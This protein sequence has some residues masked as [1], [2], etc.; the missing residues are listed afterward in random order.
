MHINHCKHH[1][2]SFVNTHCD[3]GVCYRDVTT[4]PDRQDG[5]AWRKPCIVARES[6]F[7]N[8]GQREE[9]AKRGTCDKFELPTAEEVAADEVRWEAKLKETLKSLE[10]GVVPDGVFVCGP[11]TVGKCVCKCP[12]SC[13]HVWDGDAIEDEENGISTAT[14][15]IC[16]EWAMNHDMWLGD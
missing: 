11:G 12:E 14:C 2:G 7:Q 1:N 8:D 4:E 15:S 6:D 3:A 13:G 10:N 5:S 9:Y 16:G